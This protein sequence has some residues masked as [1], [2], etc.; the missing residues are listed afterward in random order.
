M[1]EG[2]VLVL[3]LTALF[4]VI[5]MAAFVLQARG[6]APQAAD[7]LVALGPTLVVLGIIFGEDPVVGY[8]MIVAGVVCAVIVTFVRREAAKA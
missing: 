1:A 3:G 4:L 2:W 6:G 8:G 5:A 7:S